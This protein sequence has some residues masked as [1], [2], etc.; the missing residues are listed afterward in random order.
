M[1]LDLG[2]VQVIAGVKLNGR[3]LG[4]LWKPPHRIDITDAAGPG[5]NALELVV[6]NLWPNRLIGDANRPED[7][8]WEATFGGQRLIKWP[9][10]LLEG[11]PSPTGRFTFATWKV[12]AKDAPL[13]R[14]GLLGPVIL[15]AAARVTHPA[16]T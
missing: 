7:C 6:V 15:S 13:K 5:S 4:V 12:W 3:D 1:Y 16:R 9:S 8:E 10:W 14:S 11:K 2:E